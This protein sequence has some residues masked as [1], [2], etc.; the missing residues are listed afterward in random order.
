[1]LVADKP[2]ADAFEQPAVVNDFT[3]VVATVNG[4]GSQTANNTIIRSLFKMGIPVNGKNIF[5]SNIAGLPTWFT[6]RASKDGYVARR[7]TTE[8]LVAFNS[9][10]ADA[11]LAALRSGGVV[12]YPEE[13]KFVNKREDVTYY[14]LPVKALVK[15]SGAPQDLRDYVA[16]MVY[17]GALAQMLGIEFEAVKD[18]LVKHFK[19]KQKPIDLNY[20]VVTSAAEWIKNNHVKKDPYRV[21][22]MNK[23]AGKI[24]IDG[25]TAGA[26]GALFGGV[27]FVAWYPITPSTSLVDAINDYLPKVRL[28]PDTGKATCAVVQA[29][30]ELAALGMV[31][32]AGWAG[33]RSMTATSGPGISLMAEFT[34]LAY[35]AEIPAVVWD[36]TRMGP[37]TGLPTRVSQGDVLFA[38]YLGHGDTKHICLLPGT[39]QECF[40]FG[41]TSFDLAERLQTP[42][43]VLSD[44]DMGM[45]LWMTDPFVMPE[46]PLD[47]GKVLTAEDLNK[48]GGFARYKDVDGDGI[49]YRT[50][51]GTRHPLAAY[52]TRGTGHNEEAGYS[53]SPDDWE[54]NLERL[55]KK[56]DTARRLV[57]KP[58]LKGSGNKVGIIAYGSTDPAILETVDR[59][60]SSGLNVDYLRLRALPLE[61]TTTKF[62]EEHDRVYVVELNFDGQMHKLL[63][64]HKPEMATKLRSI[65]YCDGLPFT[66]TFVSDR[67]LEGEKSL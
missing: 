56:H 66:A 51:P 13:Q 1:M 60:A 35:F 12:Y 41:Q 36:I 4:S 50:L 24:L 31:V 58:V 39:M 33:A 28:D 59:L 22:R 52:F 65:A 44:L 9:Q 57:P 3:I 32:G 55:A 48:L 40:E 61:D 16:T 7:E 63:Q 34:G 45:N 37:S 42:V 43:F 17:V 67:I 15:E 26:L 64:L 30:D 19:G 25:N 38:Y 14:P 54:K 6:I 2:Q 53:E 49:G 23:T 10:T 11:D 62:V 5:P 8:I 18:A 46:K 21:E 29:E 27:Q 20:G 47:R